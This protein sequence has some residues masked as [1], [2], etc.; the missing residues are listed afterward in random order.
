[1]RIPSGAF[2]TSL[3]NS[4]RELER[5]NRIAFVPHIS[6]VLFEPSNQTV[7]L[8]RPERSLVLPNTVVQHG[9]DI[10]DAFARLVTDEMGMSNLAF[11]RVSALGDP[12]HT[13]PAIS[14][15][16]TGMLEHHVGLGAIVEG[17]PSAPRAQ[18][19]EWTALQIA[20]DRLGDNPNVM[21][22]ELSMLLLGRFVATLP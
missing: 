10:R 15:Q 5:I 11:K 9:E 3:Q 17:M 16:E 22:R 14:G 20:S 4:Q 1:M 7:L 12:T 21:Q 18:G 2:D 6:A 8:V 13:E 19:P